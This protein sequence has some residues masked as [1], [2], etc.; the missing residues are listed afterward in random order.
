MLHI[1]VL[2]I[3]PGMFTG[4]LEASML[5]I[6]AQKGLLR[7][8]LHDLRDWTDD[9]H[10]SVDDRP[11]GGGP[12]MVLMVEPLVN[13]VRDLSR[14]PLGDGRASAPRL[15][16]TCPSGRRFDQAWARELAREERLLIVAGHY[17]GYDQRILELLQPEE[18][19]IGDYVLTGGEI[20]ALAVIDA[21][22]RL[23]PG[24]LGHPESSAAESF[25]EDRLLDFPQY[26]RPAEFAGLRVP[27]I[28]LS[29]DHAKVDRWRREQARERTRQRRPDLL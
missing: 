5:K 4:V 26:T 12:G 3:F 17:E 7:V 18:L 19:S 21:V 14:R 9:P 1:D 20:P 22:T 10:R 27:E 25:G 6:A 11:F 13:A 16:L 28:L 8:Q 15:L 24:V 29:G 23:I 2:T